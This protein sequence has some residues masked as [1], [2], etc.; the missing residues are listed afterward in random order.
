MCAGCGSLPSTGSVRRARRLHRAQRLA[1]DRR[2]EQPFADQPVCLLRCLL[3]DAL[4]DERP[5]HVRHRLVE[6]AGLEHVDEPCL[7]LGHAVGELVTDDVQRDREAVE[8]LAVAVAEHHLLACPRTRCCSDC[9]KWTVASS[10]MPSS[11]IE[12][13]SYTSREIPRRAQPVERFA[14]GHIRSRGGGD[15]SEATTL[16]G[17]LLLIVRAV[18]IVRFFAAGPVCTVRTVIAVSRMNGDSRKARIVVSRASVRLALSRC[19]G[20]SPLRNRVQQV[21]WQDAEDGLASKLR[22][23]SPSFP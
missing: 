11:S 3:Q 9:P 1:V 2:R 7:V 5:E 20:G 15:A 14:H 16:P 6:R 22:A 19:S 23:H 8:H 4:L 17:K 12:F 21:R 13:R 10:A 18:Q